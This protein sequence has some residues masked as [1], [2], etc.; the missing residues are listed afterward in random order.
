MNACLINGQ[1]I[2]SLAIDDRAIHY[3]DG[4]FETIA[5]KHGVMAFWLEHYQR[6]VMGCRRL[7]FPTPEEA[8]LLQEIDVVKQNADWA[9]IKIIISRGASER[10]Y[11]IPKNCKTK[12]IVQCYPFPQVPQLY[13]QQGIRACF[14]KTPVSENAYLA[15]IKHLNRLDNVLASSEWNDENIAE[16]LM[17]NVFG[18]VIQGTKSNLFCVKENVL[19]TPAL[20]SA[21]IQGIMRAQ[22]LLW[23]QQN[24]IT[25]NIGSITPKELLAQD[26]I[27]VC[28]SIL[29]IWP[30]TNL[31]G[32]VFPVGKYANELL[33]YFK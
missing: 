5:L 26:E 24:N 19:F 31:E 30:V 3:G 7:K 17:C 23:A 6:L 9:V 29:G 21:G 13:Y 27:F 32:H 16:G 12:R 10:G 18:Q 4:L 20:S 14:C 15:G 28:N 25:I 1:A 8:V 33:N 2:T 11:R 22:V